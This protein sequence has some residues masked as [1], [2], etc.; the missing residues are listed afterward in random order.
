MQEFRSRSV[1]REQ[2]D[3]NLEDPMLT[4][5]RLLW[6]RVHSSFWFLPTLMTGV[7]AAGAIALIA[8]GPSDETLAWLPLVPVKLDAAG[9]RTLLS[10][11]ATCVMTVGGVAFSITMV[12]LT[13]AASQLG[14]RLVRHFM[15]DRRTQA[16]LGAFVATFAYCVVALMTV[17]GS[18]DGETPPLAV[19]L[20]GVV[21]AVADIGVILFFVHHM[22]ISIQAPSVVARLHADLVRGL[23]LA[24]RRGSSGAPSTADE[25]RARADADAAETTIVV[26]ASRD[27][28]VQA[29]GSDSIVR[30]AREWDGLVR[31]DVKPGA[32]V[33]ADRA[34]GVLAPARHEESRR[35]ALEDA[36]RRVAGCVAVGAERTLIEDCELAIDQL[37][38]LAVRALSTG[39]NDPH[40]AMMALDYLGAALQSFDPARLPNGHYR[41]DE[42]R[43]RLLVPALE[44]RDLTALAFDEIRRHAE[45]DVA[46]T[47]RLLT[48]LG[49]F[50]SHE[51]LR[52]VDLEAIELQADAVHDAIPSSEWGPEEAEQLEAR[53]RS[54]SDALSQAAERS[55]AR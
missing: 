30:I 25:D 11:I 37:V 23:E 49:K 32:F 18:E 7:A 40:S 51:A 42:G 31:L 13:L 16:A 55:R 39:I 21:L 52:P 34:I 9:A 15:H 45:G 20:G 1:P 3:S 2:A 44:Y 36:A 47:D 17:A 26:R 8:F 41:D 38:E 48:T 28:Y 43:T 4:E 54:V 46:V 35:E 53:W 50:A 12:V 22:A 10:T 6:Q 27:G 5:F 24:T 19:V 33:I 29:I 14:A